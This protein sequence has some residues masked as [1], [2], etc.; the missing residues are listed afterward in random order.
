MSS[1]DPIERFAS[2]FEHVTSL[3]IPEPNAMC[4][5]TVDSDGRPSSRMVLLK[6][7]DERGF[8][9]FTNL[10]SRKGREI[11]ANPAVALCF[12]WQR[13]ARQVR[14]EGDA[15]AVDDEE[16]DAYFASRPRGSQIGAWASAQ[17]RKLSSRQALLDTVEEIENRYEDQTIPRP[18]YWS[19]FRVVPR[20]IEFWTGSEFRL[21][22]R[23]VFERHDDGTWI[24]SLLYP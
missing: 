6:G 13:V 22:E 16:A 23:D 20:R 14:I 18:P 10:E 9:F 8:V 7:F 12:F 5:S 2:L 1:V 21:H 4:L 3:E 24:S 17:S 19:G 15:V 11:A